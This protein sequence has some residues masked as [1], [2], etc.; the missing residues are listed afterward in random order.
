MPL[1]LVMVESTPRQLQSIEWAI[2]VLDGDGK[3]ELRGQE[4]IW[5]PEPVADGNTSGVEAFDSGSP[6]MP[7]VEPR[8]QEGSGPDA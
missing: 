7:M 5:E 3:V 1:V 6:V 8:E 4:A 2:A